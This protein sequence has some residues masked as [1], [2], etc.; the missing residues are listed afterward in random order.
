MSTYSIFFL[1]IVQKLNS[2][3]H[4]IASLRAHN[5]R[6]VRT[7][8]TSLSSPSGLETQR[9]PG[10]ASWG[11]TQPVSAHQEAMLHWTRQRV[12]RSAMCVQS[13]QLTWSLRSVCR[14]ECPTVS[15]WS[16][17]QSPCPT[18]GQ[19]R[20]AP[21]HTTSKRLINHIKGNT[22]TR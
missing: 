15:S 4:Q 1:S 14:A 21:A 2:L 13:T 17:A 16:V 12:N 11:R 9:K 22:L 18:S 20:P 7:H 3:F 5:T 6:S 19:P 10:M 8:S